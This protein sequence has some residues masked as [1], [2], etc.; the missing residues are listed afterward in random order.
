MTKHEQRVEEAVARLMALRQSLPPS[1]VPAAD[2][3]VLAQ[4]DV[5]NCRRSAGNRGEVHREEGIT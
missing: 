1:M 4:Y 3:R 2:K 5:R